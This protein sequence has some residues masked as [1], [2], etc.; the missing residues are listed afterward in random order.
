MNTRGEK[1]FIRFPRI[2]GYLYSYMMGAKPIQIQYHEIASDL[3]SHI[4]H[5]R[6]LDVGTG[7]GYL[8]R[9]IH[10]LNPDI[11]LYGL[12]ISD[13]MVAIARRNLV[14]I[15]S[16]IQLGTIGSTDYPDEYFD[17]ITCSGSFYL[18]DHP[19]GCLNEIWRILRSGGNGYL[20]ETHKDVDE[21]GLKKSIRSNLKDDN[22]IRRIFSPIF[23]MKQLRMTYSESE[24][25]QILRSSAFSGNYR[26][27]RI[28]VAGL[29]IWLR[30]GLFKF[31]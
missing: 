6:L 19:R 25:D 16:Q 31:A 21:S 13:S 26:I 18:W 23:L 2:A 14:S 27:D 10:H 28:A 1:E 8:L 9:E 15:I 11:E 7:P 5:G 22:F 30:L 17:V 3:V 12:D 4:K 29:P 24:I 20:F